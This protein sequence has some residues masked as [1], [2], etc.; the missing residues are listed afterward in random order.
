MSAAPSN[1]LAL[2][3]DNGMRSDLY[4]DQRD[5][6]MYQVR[7]SGTNRIR[8]TKLYLPYLRMWLIQNGYTCPDL[9]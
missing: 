9:S 8:S 1:A 4:V 3:D 7:E 2:Y 5:D 6:G